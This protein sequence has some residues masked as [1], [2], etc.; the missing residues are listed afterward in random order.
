M[1]AIEVVARPEVDVGALRPLVVQKTGTA[2]DDRQIQ[3]TIAALMETGKF[4]H[5][6]V[7]VQPETD[8]LRLIVICK[9]VY[10]LGIVEFPGATKA[11]NYGQL[12]QV[13]NYSSE[14]PY[15][16]SWIGRGEVALLKFLKKNGYFAARVRGERDLDKPHYLANIVFHVTLNRRARVGQVRVTGTDAKEAAHLE[17]TVHSLHAKL[18][19][20]S[21]AHGKPYH[22]KRIQA[23]VGNMQHELT[24]QGHVAA[25][26]ETEAPLFHAENSRADVVFTVT[27]GPH[28]AID[29]E[30]A[31]L[32][33]IPFLNHWRLRDQVPIYEE[34]SVDPDLIEEGKVN[35][36]AYFRKQGYF[37]VK[38]DETTKASPQKVS[39]LYQVDKSDKHKVESVTVQGGPALDQED[40]AE[41][42][43]VKPKGF[44]SR[45]TFSDDL[46]DQ[47]T[48]TLK[49]FYQ[50]AGYQDVKVVP[51]VV[52]R[53][54]NLYITFRVTEGPRT[55]VNSVRI[56][57]N[58]HIPT[59]QLIRRPLDAKPGRPYSANRLTDDRNHIAAIYL[60]RGY[61]Q[62]AVESIV[63]ATLN[64]P[65]G[66]DVI[67]KVEE[68]IQSHV[69]GVVT[70]GKEVTRQRL[71]DRTANVHTGEPLSQGKLLQA[72]SQL[73]NLGIFDWASVEPAG[74]PSDN[75]A[76]PDQEV[77]IKVHEASRN[78]ITY[79]GGLEVAHKGGQIPAGTVALPGLPPVFIANNIFVNSQATLV[80]PR[81]S[82]EYSRRNLLGLDET[83]SLALL[84]GRLDQRGLF[85]YS[86]PHMLG[87]SWSAL[88]SLSAER[89]SE[90]PIYTARL[91]QASFQVEKPVTKHQTVLLRYSYTRTDLSNLLIPQLVLPKDRNVTLSTLGAAWVNDTRDRPLDPHRGVYQTADFNLSPMAIGSSANFAR[92]LGQTAYYR[93][94]FGSPNI[95][96]ANSIR[97]GLAKGYAGSTVPLS[98]SFFTGGS[99]TLRGFPIDGAGP[100]R[101]VPVCSN[102]DNPSTCTNIN[103]PVGGTQLLIL[104]SEGRFPTGLYNGLQAAVFYDGG[105][106]FNH[107]G[108]GGFLK[109]YTNTVGLGLRYQTPV[110]PIRIDVGRLL[111]PVRGI[112]PTQYYITIGEAF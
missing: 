90:N 108:F 10:Y 13:V 9:P 20:E 1:A 99:T 50:D 104:N 2:Y 54:P 41:N 100:Q 24:E 68:G 105:N 78:S 59:S 26:I 15:Q 73:Y 98:E 21:L 74:E 33:R 72:E 12:L 52:D 34:N 82:F 57:G 84:V 112:S 51:R 91:G 79:G 37:D 103:V 14:D 60:N 35:L 4:N 107:L 29:L 77:L 6:S 39:V 92:F 109:N 102:P 87:G 44:L 46:L 67:Y 22:P 23:A 62:A 31:R 25:K 111:N 3:A 70:L 11:F 106:V 17:Y 42:L 95:I 32:S 80:S 18:K 69:S 28:V 76:N 89:T 110:G 58:Q 86:D 5:I 93:P 75:S 85:S 47:S 19:A 8:G 97:A 65:D 83:A 36:T 30:G 64:M 61:L 45:G 27:L 66:V 7:K 43:G 55:V 94:M 40:L 53:E 38:V 16:T 101:T 81:G 71:I 63:T 88:W 49:A 56:E 48:G 96:W